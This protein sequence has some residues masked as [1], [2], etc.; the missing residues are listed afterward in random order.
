MTMSEET[1]VTRGNQITLTKEIREKMHIR[2]GDKVILNIKGDVLMVS[3]RDS[4][5]FDNFEDFLPEKF[6]KTL[7]KIRTDEKERLKRL[8]IIE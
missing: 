8:G 1:I 4:R 5:V 2:E 3:K 7:K 6:E